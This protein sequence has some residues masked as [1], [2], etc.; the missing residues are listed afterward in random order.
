MFPK[1]RKSKR[2]IYLD[3]AAATPL[4]P[5]V[6]EAMKPF[7]EKRYGNSSSLHKEGREAKSAIEIA[8]KTIADLI[9]V[10]S[11]EVVFTA[12][13]TESAN[14]A[15]FGVARHFELAH[16]RKGHIISSVIEHR[17]V[18]SSIE[19][20]VGEGWKAS[21]IKADSQGFIKFDQ[22][23]AAVRPDTV[24]I[25]IIYAN[26]EIGTIEPIAQIGKWL[27]AQNAKRKAQNLP[28]ILFHTDACQAAGACD[29]NIQNLGVDL[30][31][32]NGS[33]IYGPKQTGFLYVRSGTLLEPLIYGGGQER[34]LR[35]G[36]EN[37]SGIVG[38]AKA[39]ELVQKDRV[40]E[41]PRLQEL[42]NYFINLIFKYIP[43]VE[44]NGP[45]NGNDFGFQN[46]SLPRGREGDWQNFKTQTGQKTQ[47]KRLPNNVNVSF[48][49]LEGESLVLYL[50]AY[51][52]CASSGSACSSYSSNPYYVFKA[53]GKPLKQARGS[54][55][56]TLGKKTTKKDIDYV[57]KILPLV[58]KDL[59]K[60]SN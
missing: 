20:L 14:L 38:L 34:G 47:M 39:F 55:R 12:G 56:F 52:I 36:T 16:K 9:G 29:V 50:D 45:L 48:I 43:K 32:I 30:M 22:L 23:K 7:W 44:L 15:I 51:G 27:K 1:V 10:R 41:N 46:A 13:G 21:F 60:S 19:R 11:S 24:L 59:R 17:A 8:R 18:L 57:M 54:V 6:K 42:S 3:Y 2:T 58:V 4:A 5:L 25:S 26:N 53:L 33:K 28:R 37:V 35:S 40:K 31:T 49:G